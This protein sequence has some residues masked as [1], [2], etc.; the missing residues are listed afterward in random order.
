MLNVGLHVSNVLFICTTMFLLCQPTGKPPHGSR[1]QQVF[2]ENP[3]PKLANC[4]ELYGGLSALSCSIVRFILWA[5]IRST[6]GSSASK[7]QIRRTSN[8]ATARRC[9]S[10]QT[11]NATRLE[12]VE[13]GLKRHSHGSTSKYVF[14]KNEMWLFMVVCVHTNVHDSVSPRN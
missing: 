8:P 6:F 9:R 3:Y 1:N 5:T 7:Q 10:P 2:T 11:A 4:L 14:S 12:V 13:F